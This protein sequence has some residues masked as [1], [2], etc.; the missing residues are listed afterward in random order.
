MDDPGVVEAAQFAIEA[1]KKADKDDS[2]TL[3]KIT[4]AQR[5]VVQ[6]YSYTLT[7][8][9]K[10]GEKTRKAVAVVWVK[11]VLKDHKEEDRN[12][13]TSWKWK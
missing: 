9:V 13:L 10:A 4:G 3:V 5:Q 7:L 6:G 12:Q 1:Q 11:P 2:L 8:S